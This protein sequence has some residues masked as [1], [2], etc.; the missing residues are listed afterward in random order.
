MSLR[1]LFVDD[2]PRVLDGLRRMLRPLRGEWEMH[3]ATSGAEALAL[4]EEAAF[5][6]VVTDMRMPEMD[7]AELLDRVRELH[8]DVV[9]IVL[10]GHSDEETILRAVGPSHRYL[11]KPCDP[12]TLQRTI[13]SSRSLV[14][15]LSDERLR[16][17]VGQLRALPSQPELY[18]KLIAALR[19][20]ETS[21]RDVGRIVAGDPAMTAQVLR[22]VNSSYFGLFEEVTRPERAVGLLGMTTVA[23]LLLGFQLVQQADIGTLERLGLGWVWPHSVATAALA[24]RI[25]ES[26]TGDAKIADDAFAA[27]MVHDAGLLILA[28]NFEERYARLLGDAGSDSD[29]MADAERQAHGVDHAVVGAYVLRLW[30][31]PETVIE[32]VAFHHEPAR[33]LD[34]SF[35]ALTAVHAADALEREERGSGAARL[36]DASYLDRVGVSGRWESWRALRSPELHEQEV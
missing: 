16:A 32:A 3:F 14:G 25:A 4:M 5:H 33:S 12:E 35:S 19:D 1:L 24:R 30:G 11:S 22:L 6:V 13:A 18:Q 28:T 20:P 21:T 27:G 9:R 29:A 8:P 7:G 2:E 23:S 34:L 31:L 17:L 15:I 36:G 26:E 10:S